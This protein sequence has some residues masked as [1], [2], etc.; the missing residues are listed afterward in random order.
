MQRRIF[1][2]DWVHYFLT[3]ILSFRMSSKSLTRKH[4]SF[5]IGSFFGLIFLAQTHWIL[6]LLASDKLD[7]PRVCAETTDPIDAVYTWVNGSDPI[8]LKSLKQYRPEVH[9]KEYEDFDQLRFSLR[10]I[11]QFA[12][13]IR[14]VFIVTNGQVPN[15]LNL[16]FDR[17]SIISHADI[18]PDNSHLPTFS[19]PSIEA[20]LHRIPNISDKFIYLND[21]FSFIN[22]VCP[23]DYFDESEGFKIYLFNDILSGHP[24]N[25]AIFGLTCPGKCLSLADNGECDEDCNLL[26][27]RYDDGDCDGRVSNQHDYKNPR[28]YELFYPSIDFTNILLETKLKLHNRWRKWVPHYPFMI[29]KSIMTELQMK[30]GRFYNQ[31]SGHRFRAKNDVQYAFM[32]SHYVIENEDIKSTIYNGKKFGTYIPVT[33]FENALKNYLSPSFFFPF[34]QKYLWLC[35]NAGTSP[36]DSNDQKI[37]N[38]VLNWYHSI[39]PSISSFEMKE[40]TPEYQEGVTIQVKSERNW[41]WTIWGIQFI[42]LIVIPVCLWKLSQI[43]CNCRDSQRK[44]KTYKA[45]KT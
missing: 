41:L 24:S 17:V 6:S 36:Q 34:S 1:A 39:Y 30:I 38:Q 7:T 5:L 45:L 32:Y 13:W 22:T 25:Q 12:P 26:A 14:H 33:N 16:E 4:F 40:K 42:V 43:I 9:E 15:W 29:S 35:N 20:H 18:Y 21:D 19:S 31:T 37:R 44:Y 3:A 2:V 27:C 23:E 10:S 8:F 11:E 28:E